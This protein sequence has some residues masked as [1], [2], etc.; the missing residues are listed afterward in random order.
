MTCKLL[1][2][3]VV[4]V[5]GLL[6]IAG[7]RASVET[8]PPAPAPPPPERDTRVVVIREESEDVEDLARDV[9]A[10]RDA[11]EEG[12]ALKRLQAWQARHGTTFTIRA[13]RVDSEAAIEDPS[14]AT[15]PV[16]AHVTVFRGQ[17]PIH[18]FRFVPKDNRN[19][20]L[21]GS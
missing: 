12:A 16:R 17:Q 1:P 7:C 2:R 13:T 15:R 21:L 11:V 8:N 10:A 19:L 4:R 6:S 5:V 9:I 14:T 20:A 3:T 18:E